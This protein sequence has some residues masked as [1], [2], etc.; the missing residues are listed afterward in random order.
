MQQY[1]SEIEA[2]QPAIE[3]KQEVLAQKEK[4]A[5][6]G[7]SYSASYPSQ[8]LACCTRQIN[9]RRGDKFSFIARNMAALVQGFI[10][11]SVFFM[12][13]VTE[14]GLLSRGG[15]LFAAVLFNAMSATLELP[16]VFMG[17]MTLQKHRAYALYRPSAFHLSQVITDIPFLI[18]QAL[19]FS[20][21]TYWMYGLG[22]FLVEDY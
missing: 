14:T 21:I 7:G 3:F 17:R 13:P 15:G 18:L 10:Y 4:Y 20:I 11:A 1:E 8:V 16:F 12:M 22:K 6:K 5:K 2:N 19:I 9:L